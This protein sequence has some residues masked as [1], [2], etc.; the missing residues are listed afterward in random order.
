LI[1]EIRKQLIN[2][3]DFF[4]GVRG[5]DWKSSFIFFLTATLFISLVTPVL[6]YFGMESTDMSSSY[7]AQII[8]YNFAKDTL[9][10]LY[11]IYAYLLQPPR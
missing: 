7:Q 6:N 3:R 11:G 5:N 1:R 10:P 9:I 8:A 4:E 2:P